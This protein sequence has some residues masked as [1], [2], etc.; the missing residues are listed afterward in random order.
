MNK[1]LRAVAIFG[2]SICLS[3]GMQIQAHGHGKRHDGKLH[4]ALQASQEKLALTE[5][6]QQLKEENRK[7]K[8][9]R[10]K[11][12]KPATVGQGIV[13]A[14]LGAGTGALGFFAIKEIAKQA[15]VGAA[16][17]GLLG[18]AVPLGLGVVIYTY[19]R[20]HREAVVNKLVGEN[21]LELSTL[22]AF[23]AFAGLYKQLG[24]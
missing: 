3:M 19:L 6:N 22:S 13:A 7:L 8:R 2:L 1:Q 24:L 17:E 10:R 5:R 23:A 9:E 4:E 11:R 12:E 16:K 20:T 15:S 14:G 18:K 21:Y